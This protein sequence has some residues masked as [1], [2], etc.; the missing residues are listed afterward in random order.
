MRT[1]WNKSLEGRKKRIDPYAGGIG[2]VVQSDVFSVDAWL[3]QNFLGATKSK[4]TLAREK[5]AAMS[6]EEH[7]QRGIG[8]E[9]VH[10]QYGAAMSD[11]QMEPL[12][13]QMDYMYAEGGIASLMKKK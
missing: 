9:R 6:D 8:Y 5:L 2:D 10:P 13:E 7:L 1:E 4:S 12:K 11:K 3:P